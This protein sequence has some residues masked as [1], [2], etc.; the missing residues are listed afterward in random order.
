MGRQP[1][2]PNL[3]TT[4]P[5]NQ[6]TLAIASEMSWPTASLPPADTLATLHRSLSD[7]AWSCAERVQS[8]GRRDACVFCSFGREE[9]E[10]ALTRSPRCTG[11]C[12]AAR[13][14]GGSASGWSGERVCVC[15][16]QGAPAAV[17]RIKGISTRR[18]PDKEEGGVLPEGGHSVH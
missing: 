5:T 1:A 18:S 2:L 4:Q 11:P 12:Q 7:C 8:V 17:P 3:P 9:G 16:R 14:H 6:P 15:E 10:C 13:G